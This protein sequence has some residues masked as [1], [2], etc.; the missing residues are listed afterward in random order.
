MDKHLDIDIDIDND[1]EK[2]RYMALWIYHYTQY[3]HLDDSVDICITR[4][5][6][7]I[8]GESYDREIL[9][10]FVVGASMVVDRSLDRGLGNLCRELSFGHATSGMGLYSR[11][12]QTSCMEHSYYPAN[13]HVGYDS[14]RTGG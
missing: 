1:S 9:N 2:D 6:M 12:C 11:R 14:F 5:E 3:S 10:S 8:V 7:D 13:A 4:H